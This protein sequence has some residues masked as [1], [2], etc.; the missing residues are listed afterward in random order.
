MPKLVSP[1]NGET[2]VLYVSVSNYSL[3]G[4]L[5]TEREKKHFPFYYISHAIHG[6]EGNYNEVEKVLFAIVMASRKLKPYYQSH[7]IKVRTNQPLKKILEGK[8]SIKLRH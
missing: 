2:L 5:V 8:K 1:I 3:P 7:Q 4:V 6:F